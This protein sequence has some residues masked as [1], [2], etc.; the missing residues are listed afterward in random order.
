MPLCLFRLDEPVQAG[1]GQRRVEQNAA[2]HDPGPVGPAA[3]E[4]KQ[5]REPVH[6]VRRDE[7]GEQ[8]AL[9]MGLTHEPHVA[10]P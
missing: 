9:V 6:E 3:V 8:P 7:T 1:L 5:E 10:E 2:L 4:R